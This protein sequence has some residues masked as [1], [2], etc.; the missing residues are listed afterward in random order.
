MNG[1]FYHW[2]G[3][4]PPS[5]VHSFYLCLFLS[6][7]SS[8]CYNKLKSKSLGL[9]YESFSLPSHTYL[10]IP[11]KCLPPTLLPQA[12]RTSTPSPGISHFHTPICALAVPSAWN[13]TSPFLPLVNFYFS[14][15][16]QPRNH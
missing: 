8:T 9:V 10:P 2:S 16:T 13:S 6:V 5:Q 12:Q 15:K 3:T 7:L 11:G 4:N 14:F 1:L